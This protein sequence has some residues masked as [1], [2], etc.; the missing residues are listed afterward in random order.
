MTASFPL[1]VYSSPFTVHYPFTVIYDQPLIA[2][3]K[4]MEN[5]KQL[6]V[7]GRARCA[8]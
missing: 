2:S 4:C 7:N 5:G 3:G 1:S 6:M 8:L